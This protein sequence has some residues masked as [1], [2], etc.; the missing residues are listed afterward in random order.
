MR[1]LTGLWVARRQHIPTTPRDIAGRSCSPM[2]E[3]L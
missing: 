3:S 1:T 2:K